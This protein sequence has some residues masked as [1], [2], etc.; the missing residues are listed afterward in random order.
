MTTSTARPR[1]AAALSQRRPA[2]ASEWRA[3][4][5]LAAREGWLVVRHPLHLAGWI[6]VLFDAFYVIPS[7]GDS[8]AAY[9]DLGDAVVTF[10]GVLTFFAAH[11]CA[12]RPARSHAAAWLDATV[13]SPAS[14]TT[15]QCLAAIAPFAVAWALLEVLDP[16]VGAWTGRAR[17]PGTLRL[18]GSA[19]CVLGAGLLAVAVSRW[20]RFV[21]AGVVAMTGVIAACVWVG[22][23]GGRRQLLQPLVDWA[24][25]DNTTAYGP[26]TGVSPGSPGWHDVYIAG[27][28]AL[29][30]CAALLAHRRWRYPVLALAAA[31][32]VLTFVAGFAQLP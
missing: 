20:L 24:S 13:T 6:P 1:A 21:G 4:F 16:I 29:A 26:F 3:I 28:A 5:V 7:H 30:L 23:S 10:V 12:T 14:R 25:W 31:A 15:V 22:N 32:A 11:L 17:D 2:R 18:L 19:L 8:R 9:F 27:W